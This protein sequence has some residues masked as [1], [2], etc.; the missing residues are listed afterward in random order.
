MN[1]SKITIVFVVDSISET[2][3]PLRLIQGLDLKYFNPIILCV[4]SSKNRKS[5]RSILAHSVELYYLREINS[6]LKILKKNQQVI[7]HSHHTRS[8]LLVLILSKMRI[9]NSKYCFTLHSHFSRYSFLQKAIFKKILQ[10]SDLRIYNSYSTLYSINQQSNE[11]HQV[12]YNGVEFVDFNKT[13][14]DQRLKRIKNFNHLKVGIIGRLE[15]IKNVDATLMVLSE[16][17]KRNINLE[18]DIIGSGSQKQVLKDLANTLGIQHFCRFLDVMPHR[19]VMRLY[20]TYDIVFILSSQE[21]FCNV[22]V[23]AASQGCLL[24]LSDIEVFREMYR[25]NEV[26]FADNLD[27]IQIANII[28]RR[29]NEIDL[30]NLSRNIRTSYSFENMVGNYSSFYFSLCKTDFR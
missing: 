20:Q 12:I 10:T 22:A 27:P 28:E 23:E 14:F 13:N 26:I 7:I 24:V 19:K 3:I 9:I 17:S 11:T 29:R 18:V 15:K 25:N 2:S 4:K 30:F 8:S 16:F 6:L 1:Q 21:G 5:E